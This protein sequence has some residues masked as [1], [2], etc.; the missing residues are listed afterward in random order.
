MLALIFCA[1]TAGLLSV[2]GAV[3]SGGWQQFGQAL[4]DLKAAAETD[5][6]T[7]QLA[8]FAIGLMFYLEFAAAILAVARFGWGSAWREPIAWQPWSL[9]RNRKRVILIFAF[10]LLYSLAANIALAYFYPPSVSWFKVPK[11]WLSLGMVFSLAVILAPLTEELLFRGWIYTGLRS[12]IG[13]WPGLLLSSA[14]FAF[15][16]HEESHLYA[17]AVFP[18]DLVLG[19]LREWTGSIKPP[20]I[21]HSLY[22]FT[23]FWLSYFDIG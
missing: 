21:F 14:L 17:L 5:G 11:D 6:R 1:L 4:R 2:L 15:A 19:A 9:W 7:A 23:A 22:N 20:M 12:C 13:I 16:H 10:T 18:I 8:L 3:L